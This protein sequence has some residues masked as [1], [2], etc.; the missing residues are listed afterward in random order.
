MKEKRLPSFGIKSN[1]KGRVLY[2]NFAKMLGFWL[3]YS[4]RNRYRRIKS[5]TLV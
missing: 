5:I 4:N 2:E 1:M 3:L